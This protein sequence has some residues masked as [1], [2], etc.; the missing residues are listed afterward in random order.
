MNVPFLAY[1]QATAACTWFM[2]VNNVYMG[3]AAGEFSELVC[4]CMCFP[5]R[6]HEP[7]CAQLC[8]LG[9]YVRFCVLALSSD[10]R[11][12]S[13]IQI[14][15]GEKRSRDGGLHPGSPPVGRDDGPLR[16]APA[17]HELARSQGGSKKAR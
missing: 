2:V 12:T 5:V 17:F 9:T 4:V 8:M 11:G 13:T 1:M 15:F 6:A 10:S 7:H 14:V 3:Q 16:L